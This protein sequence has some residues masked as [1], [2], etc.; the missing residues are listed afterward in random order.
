MTIPAKASIC[1]LQ[2]ASVIPKLVIPTFTDKEDDGEQRSDWVLSQ[3]DFTG[4]ENWP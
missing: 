3:I 4:L 1:Q 2:E